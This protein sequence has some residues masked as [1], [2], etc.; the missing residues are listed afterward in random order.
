MNQLWNFIFLF[1]YFKDCTYKTWVHHSRKKK[2]VARSLGKETGIEITF[3]QMP[4]QI[5]LL[6]TRMKQSGDQPPFLE[7]HICAP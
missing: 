4:T 3:P 2:P 7:L 6:G 1:C 5:F